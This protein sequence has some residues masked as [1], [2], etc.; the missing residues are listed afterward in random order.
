MNI[1][2]KIEL[3]NVYYSYPTRPDQIIL[4]DISFIV[5]PG[6]QLALEGYSGS[7]K[8]KLIQLLTRFYDVEDDKGEILIIV[9]SLII[10][11]IITI[12]ILC[13]MYS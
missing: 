12:I 8:N 10:I 3:R 9:I 2:D 6:Q 1:K 5:Y 13:Y 4:K 7:G 11:M